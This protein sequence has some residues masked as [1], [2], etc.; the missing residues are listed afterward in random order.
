MHTLGLSTV[1]QIL[2][3]VIIFLLLN[4]SIARKLNFLTFLIQMK[5]LGIRNI[6]PMFLT[7]S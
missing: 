7:F 6:R 4:K 2:F 5:D 3:L 1:P